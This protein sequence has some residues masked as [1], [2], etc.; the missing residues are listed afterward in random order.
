VYS[1]NTRTGCVQIDH[2]SCQEC[3]LKGCVKACDKYG[4]GI[5][6]L[7][8]GKAVLNVQ[9]EDAKRRDPECL[10]CEVECWLHGKQAIAIS[11]PMT[12]LEQFRSR[13]NGHTAR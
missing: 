12:G 11:L 1:F 9:R 7:E 5:L 6:T 4:A 8:D 3:T 10:A 2:H 13:T